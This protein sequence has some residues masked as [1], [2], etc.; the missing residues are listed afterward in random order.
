MKDKKQVMVFTESA[1]TF[2]QSNDFIQAKYKD[3]ISFWEMMI[4]GKMCTMIDMKDTDFHEYKIYVKDLINFAGLEKNGRLYDTIIEAATKLRRREISVPLKDEFGKDWIL[5]TYLVTGVEKMVNYEG[6]ENVYVALTIHP[7]LKP[8]LLQL[9]RDFTKFDINNYKFLHSGTIT[10]LYQLLKSYHD[11]GRKNPKFELTELK[12]MLGVGN[13]YDLYAN[14][15]IKVLDESAKRFEG[16]DLRFTYTEL[17]QGKRVVGIQFNI[18]SERNKQTINI[19]PALKKT[20]NGVGEEVFDEYFPT[21]KAFGV[22]EIVFRSLLKKYD[23]ETIERAIRVTTKNQKSGKI[24]DS[25]AG[26]FVEAVRSGYTDA[27]EEKEKRKTEPKIVA[28]VANLFQHKEVKSEKSEIQKKNFEKEKADAMKLLK[29][30]KGLREEVLTKI[31]SSMFRDV[32][33]A[34]KSFD[35]NLAKPSFLA[36]VLNAMKGL[37]K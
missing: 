33:D 23:R 30:D 2:V 12:D 13:K 8:F 7:K 25:A 14:F 10:R 35:E 4:F 22:T 1:N 28:P 19:T 26:F 6:S 20:Q 5:D 31:K 18:S 37:D 17:K 11:R 16:T 24:K 27:T 3:A 29:Q 34:S 21:I 32:Y 36:A 9:K 15:R